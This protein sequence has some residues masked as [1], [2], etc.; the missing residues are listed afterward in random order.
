MAPWRLARLFAALLVTAFVLPDL[1]WGL[2][3]GLLLEG[4]GLELLGGVT[5]AAEGGKF[6]DFSPSED[7]NVA[8]A[9]GGVA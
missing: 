5:T 7:G 1:A 8:D 9:E 3:F 2:W 6:G 4:E